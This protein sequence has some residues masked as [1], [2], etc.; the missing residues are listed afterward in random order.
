MY[1]C[2]HSLKKASRQALPHLSPR[3]KSSGYSDTIHPALLE[4]LCCSFRK[5]SLH[6]RCIAS[7]LVQP[8]IHGNSKSLH[9]GALS[10]IAKQLPWLAKPFAADTRSICPPSPWAAFFHARHCQRIC[11]QRAADVESRIVTIAG[12]FTF[13]APGQVTCH[14]NTI[15]LL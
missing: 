11:L 14:P 10:H 6:F 1:S 12:S 7:E 13:T 15:I 4:G 5:F 3:S 2:L 9:S 8:L